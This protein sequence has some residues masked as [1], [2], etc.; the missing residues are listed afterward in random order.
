[1][2][3]NHLYSSRLISDGLLKLTMTFALVGSSTFTISSQ[4]GLIFGGGSTAKA[5]TSLFY[6][7]LT[8][9]VMLS[10]FKAIVA[11]GAF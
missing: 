1:M 4:K 11:K 8:T 5:T 2:A 9:S 6:L 7:S 10:I 3:G